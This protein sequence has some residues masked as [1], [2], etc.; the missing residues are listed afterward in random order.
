MAAR[1][2]FPLCS[3]VN[4]PCFGNLEHQTL[5]DRKRGKSPEGFRDFSLLPQVTPVKVK[6]ALLKHPDCSAV[7]L[8]SPE[9][10]GIC[11]T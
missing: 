7:L 8:T 11:P 3:S 2:C 9:Y 1:F 10:Y 4:R 6:E 5:L